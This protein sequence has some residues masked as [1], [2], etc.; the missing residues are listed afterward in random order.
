MRRM[1]HVI[2]S[3]VAIVAVAVLVCPVLAAPNPAR[4]ALNRTLPNLSFDGVTLA[5]ALEFLRDVSGANL[6]VNWP[7][8]ETIGV[9][10]DTPVN[11]RLRTVTLRKVLSLLLQ[12]AGSGTLT[13]FVDD[14]V[15]HVTTLEL[16]DRDMLTRVYPIQDLI[17]EVPDFEGPTLSLQ[18]GSGGGGGGQGF[19]AG[20]G[21]REEDEPPTRQERAEQII[22]LITAVIRPEVWQVNGG[23]SAIRFWNGNLIVTAPRSVHEALGGPVD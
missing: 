8:L 16:A 15:I 7:A 23:T 20:Q 10:K 4:S 22:E 5:D 14:G 9:S 21:S 18:T 17:L 3:A 12:E 13:F 19:N 1:R 11:L 2:V 6:H